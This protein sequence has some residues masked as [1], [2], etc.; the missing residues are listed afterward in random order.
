MWKKKIIVVHVNGTQHTKVSAVMAEMNI[1]QTLDAWMIVVNVG[2][3][4]EMRKQEII[5]IAVDNKDADW[6]LGELCKPGIITDTYLRVD[7][8]SK[9]LE[10]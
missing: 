10:T 2:R 9:T 1:V 4:L 5:Y 8:K 3:V 7:R 6:F